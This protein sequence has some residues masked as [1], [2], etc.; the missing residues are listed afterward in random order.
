M[1]PSYY[2]APYAD[3]ST[4]EEQLVVEKDEYTTRLPIQA[5]R[6][7]PLV[8]WFVR[9]ALVVSV[10]AN[11]ALWIRARTLKVDTHQMFSPAIPFIAYEDVVTTSGFGRDIS[12]YM[13]KPT[14]EKDELWRGLYNFGISRIP[15]KDAAR[16]ANRTVPI[17][18]DPGYYAVTLDVFHELHCLNAIRRRLW[19]D[20][21]P[22]PEEPLMDMPH[23]D[24]CVDMIRQN[25]MCSSDITPLPWVWDRTQKKALAVG[26]VI[27]TCRNF[28][29]IRQWG[30]DNKVREFNT[31]IYV[32]DP[33]GNMEIN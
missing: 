1:A 32:E 28:D 9:L 24:H 10:V 16:L 4:E 15:M 19:W 11:L 18:N 2:R 30:I 14:P 26:K 20:G 7:S 3:P 12:P 29:M 5:R 17:G 23:L 22:D 27:R 31:S 6:S 33:L 13:G 21:V 25:L 8:S